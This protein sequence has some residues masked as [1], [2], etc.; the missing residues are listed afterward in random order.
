M[1]RGSISDWPGI[2]P[3]STYRSM[4]IQTIPSKE[5]FATT[6]STEREKAGHDMSERYEE[7]CITTAKQ[8]TIKGI[9][10]DS[11]DKSEDVVDVECWL[12]RP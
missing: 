3:T 6:Q 1:V 9:E 7:Y 8:T 10:A 12:H 5:G 4:N 11:A 2:E